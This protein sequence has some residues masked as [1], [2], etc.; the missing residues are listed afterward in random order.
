MSKVFV[1]Y[2]ILPESREV[3]LSFMR[4][5]LRDNETLSLLE[6]TDQPNLFV[7]I[8]TPVSP[9]EYTRMREVRIGSGDP[10]WGRMHPWI[11]GG[12]E[13]LHIWH[14]RSIGPDE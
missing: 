1:E 4:E 3:Y 2:A 12:R 8:W 9:D 5:R 11:K 7:E 10:I 6:G 14:F 13:K